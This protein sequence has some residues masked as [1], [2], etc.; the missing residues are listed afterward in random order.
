[1][2]K[3]T[4]KDLVTSNRKDLILLY[5]IYKRNISAYKILS[6]GALNI[7]MN[8][9]LNDKNYEFKYLYENN[10]ILDE[11]FLDWTK[12]H[13]KIISWIKKNKKKAMFIAF[14]IL[15]NHLAGKG[16]FN[17]KMKKAG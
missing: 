9:I 5:N 1:M 17:I 7:I 11:G 2:G 6:E 14:A 15:M 13:I 12:K 4:Y 16:V 3:L 8:D 10:I